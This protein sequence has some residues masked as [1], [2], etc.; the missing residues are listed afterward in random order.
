MATND[1]FGRAI[2]SMFSNLR[3]YREIGLDSDGRSHFYDPQAHEI[4]ICEG[5]RRGVGIRDD[6]VLKRLSVPGD[7]T[8]AWDYVR[9][10]REETDAEWADLNVP[11]ED[12]Y[13]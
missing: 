8:G 6:D 9:F 5:D 13:A 10:V 3:V 12:P 7:S 2:E 1:Q 11:E 4:V